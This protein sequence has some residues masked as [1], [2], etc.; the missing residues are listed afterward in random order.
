M[1]FKK[2]KIIIFL[3]TLGLISSLY[4]SFKRWKIERANNSYEMCIDFDDL[5]KISEENSRAPFDMAKELKEAGI[6]TIGVEME[7]FPR[8]EKEGRIILASSSDIEKLVL[9]GAKFR[10]VYEMEIPN[11][12]HITYIFAKEADLG[13]W[14]KEKL[15]EKFGEKQVLGFYRG[16][17]YLIMVSRAK[18][19]LENIYLGFW[20]RR[21]KEAEDLNL[22]IIL[23]VPYD[24]FMT[25]KW[26]KDVLNFDWR[27]DF[28]CI[29]FVGE[30]VPQEENK[31]EIIYSF[32]SKKDLRIG[33]AE[34][35]KV[36]G[37]KSYLLDF[38]QK[39][40]GI[41]S[42]GKN[43]IKKDFFIE[44]FT[45][46]VRER[47]MRILYLHPF[48]YNITDFIDILAGIKESLL[49][50]GFILG[51]AETFGEFRVKFLPLF[52]IFL[53]VF[54]AVYW[55]LSLIFKLST[56][57]E[58]FYV[59]FSVGVSIV[60]AKEIILRQIMA[61]IATIV[62]PV[63]SISK[64]WK[65]RKLPEG[66]YTILL[67]L[68]ITGISLI[69]ALHLS[70]L[71]SETEFFTKILIF[72][73]VK[74]SLI[75]PLI[76]S[77]LV[78]YGRDKKYFTTGLERI[79]RKRMEVRHFFLGGIII[80]GLVFLL[81]RAGNNPGMFF[82][83]GERSIRDILENLF[84]VRPRFKE[85]LFGHPLMLLGIYIYVVRK[86]S[87]FRP[88]LILG[89]IGQVSLINTFAHLHTPLYISLMR[90]LNGIFLG[91]FVGFILIKIY[92][93]LYP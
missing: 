80:L 28:S 49:K 30:K 52:F 21:I 57:F 5:M 71:L 43:K 25:E 74:L 23:K 4:V 26:L 41:H 62:F 88:F 42:I 78:L 75:L 83:P 14:I 12:P 73:G 51:K 6:T 36:K 66:L 34:F 17:Y 11:K 87:V 24:N 76:I 93:I 84:F 46:A 69:G 54:A 37:L 56:F 68:G 50:K 55:L 31:K 89:L 40:I 19:V 58:I 81:L 16:T 20:D 1:S 48:D 65:K 47:N 70:T 92:D 22:N 82:Y 27:R 60:F 91:V 44:R 7:S 3:I 9:M 63:L 33:I 53:S 85:F 64:P 39:C 29:T 61:F 79:W 10:F 13:E 8:L 15:K 67:F 59:V 77:F 18:R 2:E 38:S 90:S 32:L 72:R 45:R 86:K 35:L